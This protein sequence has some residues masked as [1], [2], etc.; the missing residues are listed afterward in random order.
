MAAVT[1]ILQKAQSGD[2]LPL[3]KALSYSPAGT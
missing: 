2:A 3:R 1:N